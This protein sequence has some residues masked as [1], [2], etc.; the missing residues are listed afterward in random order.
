MM[1]FFDELVQYINT[2][3]VG[4]T[5]YRRDIIEYAG[6]YTSIDTYRRTLEVAGYLGKG[7]KPGQYIVKKQIPRFTSLTY[8]RKQAYGNNRVS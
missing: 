7:K 1:S 8:F 5:I 3:E 4:A 2:H 6:A